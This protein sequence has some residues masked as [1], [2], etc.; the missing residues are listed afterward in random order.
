[1]EW[2]QVDRKGLGKILA[3]KGVEFV[4]HELVQNSWDE[5]TTEVHVTLARIAGTRSVKLVVEDDNPEGFSDLSHAWTLFAESGKKVDPEKRG[6]FNFGEKLVLSLCEEASI[7]STKGMVVFDASGRHHRRSRRQSGTEFTGILRMTNE[8]MARC[9]ATMLTLIP[10]QGIKTYFNEVLLAE[11]KPM[12]ST[13]A[14]LQTEIADGEGHLRKAQRKTTIRVYEPLPGET[15]TL[16]EMGI[17]VVETGDRWHLDIAQKVPLNLDRDNVPPAYLSRI[18]ALV[19]DLMSEALTVEDANAPW[20]REAVQDHGEEMAPATISRIAD[21]RFGEK[22]VSFDPSDQEAN[23]LAASKGYTVVHGS[24]MSKNEWEAMRRAGAI[25]PAGQVTP[26]PKPF[27]PEGEQ[28]AFL[29]EADWTPAMR[30]VVSFARCVAPLLIG[31]TVRVRIANDRGWPFSATYGAGD[32]IFNAG[33]LGTE[34]FAGPT[35]RICD[36]LIHELGHHFSS[37]HLSDDYYRGLTKLGGKLVEIALE[38]PEYF[39]EIR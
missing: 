19:G 5:Q 2:F 14:S 33:A 16:Y 25:L 38:Q 29:G 7:H 6:R 36:L 15:P 4:L 35:G 12:A 31:K 27:S 13:Q 21:L 8:D 3:R 10:P 23:S 11:R 26:S 24:Q 39:A 32:L 9:A 17:P 1:V 34:W 30:K 18:R 28:V 37:N 22:R 20:L